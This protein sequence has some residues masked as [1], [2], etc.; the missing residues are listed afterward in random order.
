MNNR[1]ISVLI[2]THNEEINLPDCLASL[3]SLDAEIFIVDSHSTDATAE[4]AKRYGA[5]VYS[6]DFL[7]QA[8]QVNWAIG[9]LPM[10]GDWILRLDADERLTPELAAELASGL[11]EFPEGINGLYCRRRVIFM[12]RWI[13]HG[14][15]YPTWLLRVWRSG[16]AVC[17][18]RWMDEHMI[19]KEGRAASLKWD[20]SEDNGKDLSWWI[21]K[22]NSYATREM[23][24]FFRQGEGV[25]VGGKRVAEA[26][27]DTQ[28]K[29]KRWL[30]NNVYNK[31]PLFFR[32]LIYFVYR[33]FLRFGFWDGREGLIFHFLQGFWYRFLVD[34]KIHEFRRR[35]QREG[36]APAALLKEL[37][38]VGQRD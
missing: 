23:I 11:R 38:N 13:K 22:H 5:A 24:E 15:Y 20:I 21:L 27:L 30:K 17:E 12:G 9:N 8:Q 1:T 31:L 2:L 32:P 35:A 7:N 10:R 18:E 33:Y 16:K 25:S 34:A 37:Y 4:I 3:S 14:S 29:R 36:K 19:L 6:H 28:E 26:V